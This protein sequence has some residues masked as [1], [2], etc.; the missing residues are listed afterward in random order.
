M[1]A[2]G[3][4]S[5]SLSLARVHL[6][7]PTCL[8]PHSQAWRCARARAQLRDMKDELPR[9]RARAAWQRVVAAVSA[10]LAQQRRQQVQEEAAATALQAA[11]RGWLV[12]RAAAKQLAGIRRFQVRASYVWL[13]KPAVGRSTSGSRSQSAHAC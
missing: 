7:T 12:R 4:A 8:C 10:A 3:F 11:V 6:T 5:L 1:S 9:K 2:A 13:V